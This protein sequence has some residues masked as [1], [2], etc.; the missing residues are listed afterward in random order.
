IT[1]SLLK[2]PGGKKGKL[3]YKVLYFEYSQVLSNG[4][5]LLFAA[6]DDSNII[7]QFDADGQLKATYMPG[8]VDGKD[9]GRAGLQL[10]E[11]KNEVYVLYREQAPGMAIGFVKTFKGAG[12]TKKIEFDR[13]DELMTYGRVVKIN[14]TQLS[15]SLPVDITDD[16]ILGETPLFLGASGELLLLLRDSKDNYSI[17]RIE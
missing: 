14:T 4:D 10:I 12:V 2:T 13:V 5:I 9:F 6:T 16:L 8:R 17:G 7:F 15:C 11:N 3:S 1:K